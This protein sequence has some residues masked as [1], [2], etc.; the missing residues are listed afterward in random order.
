MIRIGLLGGPGCGKSTQC[1]HF[2]SK[3]KEMGMQTEQVQEWVREAINKSYIPTNNPWVQWWIYTEQKEKEDCLPIDIDYMVTD[4]PTILSYIYALQY[5]NRPP[6]N[7][8][9]LKMYEYFLKDLDRYDYLFVCK[10]EKPYVKDGTRIQT[11]KEAKEIDDLVLNLLDIHSVKYHIITGTVE[12]RTN[13][14]RGVIGI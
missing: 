10:R 11:E 7:Y 13:Q 3:L 2:F 5:T 6:D 8:L 4:S 9:I 14:M 12:E 1:A